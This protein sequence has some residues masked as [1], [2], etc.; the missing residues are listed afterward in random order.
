VIVESVVTIQLQSDS[1]GSEPQSMLPPEMS[2]PVGCVTVSV[3][4][5][6][7]DVEVKLAITSLLPPDEVRV[8]VQIS[9]SVPVGVVGQPCQGE[10]ELKL[11][12]LFSTAVR[13]TLPLEEE[14]V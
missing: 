7:G 1:A 2:P 8:I 4:V 14:V 9:L 5:P 12:P 13:V 6:N 3:F 11:H 10:G